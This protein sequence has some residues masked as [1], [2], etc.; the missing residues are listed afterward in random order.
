[1]GASGSQTGLSG[2]TRAAPV[3]TAE[4]FTAPK[5]A[6]KPHTVILLHLV[7]LSVASISRPQLVLAKRKTRYRIYVRGFADA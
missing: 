1:M 7:L 5:C 4:L 6:L 2:D 3:E